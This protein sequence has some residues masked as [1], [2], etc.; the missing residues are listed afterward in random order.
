MVVLDNNYNPI[1][2]YSVFVEN[3]IVPFC[4]PLSLRLYRTIL[5]N[6][7]VLDSRK[8]IPFCVRLDILVC[9]VIIRAIPNYC[10]SVTF[11]ANY[12]TKSNHFTVTHS[13]YCS[14]SNAIT[15]IILP[16]NSPVQRSRMVIKHLFY[17]ILFQIVFY[18][19]RE[20]PL[21][22]VSLIN[23]RDWI[24]VIGKSLKPK[25]NRAYA[26]VPSKIK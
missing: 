12:T 8:S 9:T 16:L 26:G 6:W 4:Y 14:R 3:D 10:S 18:Q 5:S 22:G 21:I 19:R 24:I 23:N 25:P 1:L 15:V 13:S 2:L 11:T 7:I 17:Y 20:I